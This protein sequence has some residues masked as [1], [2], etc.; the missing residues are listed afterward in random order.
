MQCDPTGG[1][2]HIDSDNEP[3]AA[4]AEGTTVPEALDLTIVDSESDVSVTSFVRVHRGGRRVFKEDVVQQIW[5][6]HTAFERASH[7][8]ECEGR[9]AVLA[10]NKDSDTDSRRQRSGRRVRGGADVAEKTIALA[11]QPHHR[12]GGPPC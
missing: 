1:L 11:G 10:E 4:M 9:F 2:T 7:H 5:A 8:T 3:L 12:S 6:G